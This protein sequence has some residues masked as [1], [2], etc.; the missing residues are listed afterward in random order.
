MT[1]TALEKLY[2]LKLYEGE[3]TENRIPIRH[4]ANAIAYAI[5]LGWNR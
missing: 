4:R 3:I 5:S 1:Y 2:G